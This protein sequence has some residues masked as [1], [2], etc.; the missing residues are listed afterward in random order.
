MS[1]DLQHV[2]ISWVLAG[3]TRLGNLRL[4]NEQEGFTTVSGTFTTTDVGFTSL[5]GS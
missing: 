1:K 5:L 3:P 4:T 2:T